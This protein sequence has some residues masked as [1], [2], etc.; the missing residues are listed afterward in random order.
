ML[1]FKEIYFYGYLKSLSR[2]LNL[3]LSF[4]SKFKINVW[5]KII[6]FKPK[7]YSRKDFV[8]GGSLIGL[9]NNQKLFENVLV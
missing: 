1:I 4:V 6:K 7:F 5:T 9:Q 2:L 8:L 3:I